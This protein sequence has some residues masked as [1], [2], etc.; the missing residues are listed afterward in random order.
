M[1]NNFTFLEDE[2]H[3]KA[4]LYNGSQKMGYC[5]IVKLNIENQKAD[6]TNPNQPTKIKTTDQD[7]KGTKP[8]YQTIYK[9]RNQ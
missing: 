9:K 8:F 7:E 1:C 2:R 4:F 3:T 5:E 6:Q